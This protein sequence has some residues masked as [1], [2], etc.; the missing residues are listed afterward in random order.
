MCAAVNLWFLWVFETESSE[1]WIPT[2]SSFPILPAGG[3]LHPWGS[4]CES[5]PANQSLGA[6]TANRRQFV[7]RWASPLTT[8][9]AA[10]PVPPVWRLL[11]VV[12][13]NLDAIPTSPC[14]FPGYRRSFAIGCFR[15]DGDRHQRLT[16]RARSVSVDLHS[17]LACGF[18]GGLE[19]CGN[20]VPR[21]EVHLVRRLTS[22]CRMGV[23]VHEIRVCSFP[24]LNN[25]I[26]FR[27]YGEGAT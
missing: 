15:S 5:H 20:V 27:R 7:S 2:F 16:C 11:S 14:R 26:V 13:R 6:S 8:E 10:D 23:T 22:E 18:P 17:G 1:F 25:F 24:V 9:C 12:A 21:A 4:R 19:F 3:R